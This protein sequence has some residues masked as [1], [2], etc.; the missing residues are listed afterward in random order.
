MGS[1]PETGQRP[2]LPR[3]GSPHA[4]QPGSVQS[5]NRDEARRKRTVVVSDVTL[6]W[7]RFRRSAYA[8]ISGASEGSIRKRR[9]AFMATL[10]AIP[11]DRRRLRRR[12]RGPRRQ[13]PDHRPQGAALRDPALRLG[14]DESAE[15]DG[16]AV[17]ACEARS[18]QEIGGHG[19]Q[20]VVRLRVPRNLRRPSHPSILKGKRR[21]TAR[22]DRIT[23]A[24]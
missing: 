3:R 8:V 1:R 11:R 22:S 18:S 5:V 19:A 13:A 20:A 10:E 12:G 17:G 9:R 23:S 4:V 2:V 16:G 14:R 24:L 7:R 15:R 6:S 21:T